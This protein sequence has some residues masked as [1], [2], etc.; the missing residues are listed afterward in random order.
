MNGCFGFKACTLV[1]FLSQLHIKRESKQ[2]HMHIPEY[3]SYFKVF[4]LPHF[5][6]NNCKESKGAHLC[7]NFVLQLLSTFFV[8]GVK[9]FT[10][11]LQCRYFILAPNNSIR[12]RHSSLLKIIV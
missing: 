5:Y 12:E 3:F 10:K 11:F 2:L 4:F 1:I 6:S 9:V 7:G 8:L